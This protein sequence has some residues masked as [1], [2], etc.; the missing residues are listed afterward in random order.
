MLLRCCLINIS[1]MILFSISRFRSIY[2]VSVQSIFHFHLHF[3]HVWLIVS[4]Q[5]Y[6]HSLLFIKKR[7]YFCNFTIAWIF[8]FF[9]KELL[10]KRSR[11][12]FHCAV[13][14]MIRYINLSWTRDAFRYLI[15]NWKWQEQNYHFSVMSTVVLS[16]LHHSFDSS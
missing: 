12:A 1:S 7:L 5:E 4:S 14:L 2:V 3:H 6:R 8:F 10:Y 13:S 16:S 15:H 11:T 9:R